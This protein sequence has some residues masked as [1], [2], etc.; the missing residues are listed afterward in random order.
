MFGTAHRVFEEL[1]V[2]LVAGA[3]VALSNHVKRLGTTF[4]SCLSI[5][6]HVISICPE[7]YFHIRGLDHVRAAMSMDTAKRRKTPSRVVSSRLDYR[8]ALLAGMLESDVTRSCSGYK[9][10]STRPHDTS[11][12]RSNWLPMCAR[13]SRLHQW[14]TISA[15]RVNRLTAP[16]SLTTTYTSKNGA[17]VDKELHGQTISHKDW[18]EIISLCC[19]Q[20]VEQSSSLQT[21]L[22]Q[23]T[24]L[25]YLGNI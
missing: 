3:S 11:P 18:T 22:K 13:D 10:P 20:D 21:T 12:S 15:K 14:S 19:G 16:S 6:K 17:I 4:D 23:S 7:L 9:T 2:G 5:D 24:A 25:A 1:C 8:N